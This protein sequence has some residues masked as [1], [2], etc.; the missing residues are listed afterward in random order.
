MLQKEGEK[1]NP[2]ES[3]TTSIFPVKINT[4]YNEIIVFY[5]FSLRKTRETENSALKLI[6]L[7]LTGIP[8]LKPVIFLSYL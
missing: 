7:I 8:L 1:K 4:I 2:L 6:R 3:K 5:F